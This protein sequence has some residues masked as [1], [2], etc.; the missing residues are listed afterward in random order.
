MNKDSKKVD[1]KTASQRYFEQHTLNDKQLSDLENIYLQADEPE[2]EGKVGT[3]LGANNAW[4]LSAVA[5]VAI[6]ILLMVLIRFSDSPMHENEERI[7]AI[8]SEV[9]KE[10]LERDPLE[11][12]SEQFPIVQ[13]HFSRLKFVPQ[14][15]QVLA[16]ASGLQGGR[17]CS[18]QKVKAAQF[19]Y[20]QGK[21]SKTLYQVAY[22]ADVFGDMPDITRKE[23]PLVRVVKGLEVQ[24]WVEKGLLMV[25]A[26]D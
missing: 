16:D 25:L 26:R 21:Q 19:R 23:Q 15:P 4:L 12:S 20:Q 9:A 17:Y 7:L 13:Q 10:H 1:L 5:S 22:D 18:I 24:L 11:I 14:K 2:G 8:A 3:V 6:F